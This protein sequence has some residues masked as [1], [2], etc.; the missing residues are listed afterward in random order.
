MKFQNLTGKSYTNEETFPKTVYIYG[1]RL[2]M[3]LVT[4]RQLQKQTFSII[5]IQYMDIIN[6]NG[7]KNHF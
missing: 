5:T 2:E 3:K 7:D 1:I 4:A 6:P